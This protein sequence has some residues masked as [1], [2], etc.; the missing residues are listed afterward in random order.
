MDALLTAGEA[1]ENHRYEGAVRIGI[2]IDRRTGPTGPQERLHYPDRGVTTAWTPVAQRNT[3][4]SKDYHLHE[5]GERVLVAHLA[6]GPERAVVL[7]AVFNEAVSTAPQGNPDNREI[8]FRDGTVVKYDPGA[9]AMTIQAAGT[10]SIT[11]EGAVTLTAPSL[12]ITVP[13]ITIKG[14]V[15]MDG[16]FD[17]EGIIL[18]THRHDEVEKGDA[19]TGE[20]VR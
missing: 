5:L 14:D 3:V 19:L 20:P 1:Q 17:L 2:V 10:L 16:T 18:N 6:N 9:K 8:V 15:R 13:Q 12:E 7:G 11:T 4:G